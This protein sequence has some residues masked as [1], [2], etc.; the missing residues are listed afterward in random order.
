MAA[1][2]PLAGLLTLRTRREEN[3]SRAVLTAEAE[4]KVTAEAKAAQGK[5][6][7]EYRV[8]HLEEKER[9]YQAI[10]G[11]TL[12]QAELDEFKAGLALLD[13][14]ELAEIE[15]L[16]RTE[17]ALTEAEAKIAAAREAWRAADRAK[18]KL[19]MHQ[20]EWRAAEAKEAAY[21]EDKELEE[22]KPGAQP[23]DP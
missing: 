12:S 9:R 21:Q 18:Q 19:L 6:L 2:Y 14:Q 17:L 7:T 16:R 1:K 11:Q 23:L 22:F 10:L 20:D 13:E 8:W 3:A 5:K 15:E 4:A